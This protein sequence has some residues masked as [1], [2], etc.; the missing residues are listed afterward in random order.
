MDTFSLSILY[1]TVNI[2][3]NKA[4]KLSTMVGIFHFIMPLI[5]VNIGNIVLDFLIFD[6]DTIE[7]LIFLAIGLQ[8]LLSINK[9][10]NIKSLT[11]IFSFLI[12][13]FTVSIDSLIIGIGLKAITENFL[14]SSL[15]FMIIST[16]FTFLGLATGKK[17]SEKFGKISTI[18]GI[19]ILIVLS[20][21][22]LI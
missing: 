7:G 12:F 6:V 19:C 2:N 22:Y 10:E 20:L 18:I 13:A 16:I 8:M 15:V 5:G 17:L 9:E 14:L 11:N 1:G 3:K 21:H 4:I